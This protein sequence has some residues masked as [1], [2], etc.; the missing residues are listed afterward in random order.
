MSVRRVLIY[1]LGS[2]GDTVVA[3]PCLHLISRKYPGA[4]RR[5]LTNFPVTGREAPFETV[6]GDSGLVHG[7]FRYPLGTRNPKELW[8]LKR[9]ISRWSPDV[10]VYLAEPRGRFNIYRDALFFRGCGIST[11][12]GV[13]YSSD[14]REHRKLEGKDRFEHESHRLLRC[15]QDLGGIN[16]DEP[17]SWDLR[18]TEAEEREADRL[19]PAHRPA[20]IVASIGTKLEVN[21]WGESNWESLLEAVSDRYP[22]VGLALVGATEEKERSGFVAAKWKGPKWNLCGSASPRGSAA[23][24]RRALLF[25]G[26]DSGPMHLAAA[27]GVPCVAI[28]SARNK[29]GIWF[30]HG[31]HHRVI[32]HRTD[33]HGCRLDRCGEHGKKCITSITVPEVFDAVSGMLTEIKV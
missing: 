7:Y 5:V 13:P 25:L 26:H 10:L 19:L 29:P 15:V 3:L 22:G 9:E 16:P 33:C 24:I 17:A 32:Y 4:E 21:D 2:L 12:V 31:S 27:V 28:F 18:L 30:P 6:I 23:L 8:A 14:L 1:R 11:L 20:F